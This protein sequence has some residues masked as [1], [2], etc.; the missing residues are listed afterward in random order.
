MPVDDFALSIIVP[1]YNEKDNVRPLVER[2]SKALSGKKFE[3]VFIDDN[4]R[5]GTAA[6]ASSMCPAY[7]VRV[8]VRTT[9]RG[10]AS[11][12][13]HGFKVTSSDIICVIDADLQHP[14][15]VV[16]GLLKAVESG[17]DIAIGSR[18]VP[19]GGCEGW[20]LTRRIISKGAVFLCHLLL[21]RTRGIKDP[22]SG[23]FMF[24][25]SVVEGASLKPKGYKILL[26]ILIAGRFKK[27]AEVAYMF[28][29]RAR[30]ESKLSS[31]TQI[32]Y[33]KHL[34]SLM[35]RSGELVRFI[36]FILVGGSGVF[37]NLGVFWLLTRFAGL[38]VSNLLWQIAIGSLQLSIT[39]DFL[40]Q[41]IAIETSIISNFTLNDLFTFRDRRATGGN[42]FARLLKFN[43]VSLAGAAIQV[44]VYAIM[45]HGLGVHDL[46]STLLGIFIATLWNFFLN[47]WFTWK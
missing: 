36:K 18:Y 20:S 21:P 9:E 40:A 24:R 35:R 47:S 41:A 23:F 28:R 6:E 32:D 26:E 3:I 2:L 38:S 42:L 7:P 13:V 1:T 22:M 14:P 11:A 12:V 34:Y 29:A 46:I 27:A 45:F 25:R 31:K 8:V 37:V 10:L 16:A 30:G 19:G 4:S 5:D 17:A 39:R 43:T 33:L 44:G 15:E